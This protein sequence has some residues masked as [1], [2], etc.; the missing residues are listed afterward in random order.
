LGA[1][2]AVG[3]VRLLSQTS[4]TNIAGA[5]NSM[6][7]AFSADGRFIVF[8]S[9]ARN[10]VIND[11]LAPNLN[12]FVRDLSAGNTVLASVNTNGIGGG[13]ADAYSPSISSNGQFVAFVSA[14]SNLVKIDTN[15]APDIFVCDM[16]SGT[17]ALVS[18]D[19]SGE[20]SAGVLSAS[21]RYRLSGN[22]LI[23]ADG[24]WVVFESMAANLVG[25]ED[26]NQ[27]TD[28]FARDLQ[29]GT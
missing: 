6:A 11:D 4:R 12:V 19:V 16:V 1:D 2:A 23:S 8:M 29:S 15:D 13:N 3:H 21:S 25:L 27:M 10:L 20:S 18:V 9:N 17:T 22:P 5:C 24:R 7:P 28:I 14:A 26:T